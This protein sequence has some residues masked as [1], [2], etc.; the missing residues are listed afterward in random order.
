MLDVVRDDQGRPLDWRGRPIVAGAQ[1]RVT[2]VGYGA[3]LWHTQ[4]VWTVVS[5]ARTR[6]EIT[7]PM[8]ATN[9]RVHF[10]TLS[11]VDPAPPSS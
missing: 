9:P 10:A 8:S 1:V 5:T 3:A 11:V 4:G 2:A 7:K 6:A